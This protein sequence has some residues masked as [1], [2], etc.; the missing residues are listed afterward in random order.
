MQGSF[1]EFIERDITLENQQQQAYES[2]INFKAVYNLNSQKIMENLPTE[3]GCFIFRLV[4]FQLNLS[5]F[6]FQG[7]LR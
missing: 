5:Y 2:F 1:P 6:R 4:Y 7:I 3:R